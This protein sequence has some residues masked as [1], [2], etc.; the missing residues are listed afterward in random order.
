MAN[1][2]ALNFG[3]SITFAGRK[4]ERERERERERDLELIKL[5]NARFCKLRSHCTISHLNWT[6]N[7][8]PIFTANNRMLYWIS[9]WEL[10]LTAMNLQETYKLAVWLASSQ[11]FFVFLQETCNFLQVNQIL[12]E[13]WKF[14]HV[15]H[16][17]LTWNDSD[18]QE[19]YKL[20]V[21]FRKFWIPFPQ[22]IIAC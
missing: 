12:Q 8:R 17:V 13:S 9:Q 6:T 4:R 16:S 14:S 1:N 2:F 21:V 11:K 20:I 15:N 5:K 19:N 18:A 22:A 7:S 10:S 3:P